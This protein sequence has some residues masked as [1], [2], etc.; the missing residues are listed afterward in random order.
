M[1]HAAKQLEQHGSFNSGHDT[2]CPYKNTML[3]Q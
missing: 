2:S 1:R 3:D